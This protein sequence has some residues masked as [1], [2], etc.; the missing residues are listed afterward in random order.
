MVFQVAHAV[1]T[2]ETT[3]DDHDT[4]DTGMVD[5]FRTHH[6]GLARDDEPSVVGRHPVGGRVANEVHLSVVAT[7]FYACP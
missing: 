1:L 6:A 7:D 3:I 5:E 2:H 4:F